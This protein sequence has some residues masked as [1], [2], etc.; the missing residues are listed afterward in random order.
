LRYQVPMAANL[1]D[2]IHTILAE[3]T[4]QNGGVL[5]SMDGIQPEKDNEALYVL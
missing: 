5:L 4:E 2:H 1:D 3:T